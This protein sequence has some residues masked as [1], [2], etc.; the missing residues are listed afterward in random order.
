[1]GTIED[2]RALDR[3]AEAARR[4]ANRVR[5]MVRTALTMSDA[6]TVECIVSDLS[7][8]GGGLIC[9]ATLEPGAPVMLVLPGIGA[10]HGTV[11]WCAGVR[12]GIAFNR[13][14]DPAAVTPLPAGASEKR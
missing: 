10:V 7:A 1:M 2:Q 6:T 3:R 14:I 8:T 9:L 4:R 13:P 11:A 5:R 12:A